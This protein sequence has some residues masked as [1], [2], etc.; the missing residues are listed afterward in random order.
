MAAA[1]DVKNQPKTDQYQ[2][3]SINQ[4]QGLSA[5]KHQQN[6]NYQTDSDY[7]VPVFRINFTNLKTDNK[8]TGTD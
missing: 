6:H 4:A 1:R 5:P 8:M 3:D 2:Y 7:A